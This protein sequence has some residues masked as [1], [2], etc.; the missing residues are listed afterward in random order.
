M[1]IYHHSKQ[2][3]HPIATYHRP[4]NDLSSSAPFPLRINL[5]TNGSAER[6]FDTSPVDSETCTKY[7]FINTR[8]QIYLCLHWTLP[9][10]LIIISFHF[11]DRSSWRR[12]ELCPTFR[13]RRYTL[14]LNQPPEVR[15]C[16]SLNNSTP[17]SVTTMVHSTLLLPRSLRLRYILLLW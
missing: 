2:T 7:I 10:S 6:S 4:T 13:S 16:F 8:P 1:I 11:H 3:S 15:T 5:T 17:K 9:Q 14:H 12:C